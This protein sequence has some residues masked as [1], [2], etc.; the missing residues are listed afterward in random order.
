MFRRSVTRWEAAR[1]VTAREVAAAAPS[2]GTT[3][4]A[5]GK[6]ASTAMR[7][8]ASFSS[9][10][11]HPRL[12]RSQKLSRQI[13]PRKSAGDYSETWASSSSPANTTST[14]HLLTS[15]SSSQSSSQLLMPYSPQSLTTSSRTLKTSSYALHSNLLNFSRSSAL[16]SSLSSSSSRSLSLLPPF[17]PSPPI[18][19]LTLSPTHDR[20]FSH[21][22]TFSDWDSSKLGNRISSSSSSTSLFSSSSSSSSSNR[23]PLAPSDFTK[24]FL[25]CLLQCYEG[26]G[27]S[28]A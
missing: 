3:T 1:G 25:S 27:G 11:Y 26:R 23:S 10:F 6:A 16:L 22:P 28:Q 7:G 20:S 24:R 15:S 14:A 19:T 9:S 4:T 18:E 17:L 5:A 2:E 12:L 13:A 21:L 8:I